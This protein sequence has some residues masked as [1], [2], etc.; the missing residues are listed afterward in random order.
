MA[1]V[2]AAAPAW[3]P[4]CAA[5]S[6]RPSSSPVE[7]GSA[8][9]AKAFPV[10]QRLAGFG[11]RRPSAEDEAALY[12][13]SFDDGGVSATASSFGRPGSLGG[14]GASRAPRARAGAGA[15]DAA[16]ASVVGFGEPA[17]AAA[18]QTPA[19]AKPA[20][21]AAAGLLRRELSG[22]T[23]LGT[24]G[25]ESLVICAPAV[26]QPSGEARAHARPS[27]GLCVR[28]EQALTPTAQ[29]AL[30]SPEPGRARAPSATVLEAQAAARYQQIEADAQA[31]TC[32][33]APGDAAA[34][35]LPRGRLLRAHAARSRPKRTPGPLVAATQQRR[36]SRCCCPL[37]SAV[38]R[39]AR[40]AE[41]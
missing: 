29:A 9:N 31:R 38:A 10:P 7:V 3:A 21:R 33:A 16:R 13:S 41:C 24:P 14:A 22:D 28:C 4:A 32:R 1:S 6:P 39:G 23:V 17:A 40:H 36:L 34:R 30:Q 2:G 25:G 20:G 12:G 18:R 15:L 26:R 8:P 27:W 19:A 37:F 5:S 35:L 11:S